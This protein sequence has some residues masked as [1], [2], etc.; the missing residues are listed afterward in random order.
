MTSIPLHSIFLSMAVK[1]R[2]DQEAM[3]KHYLELKNAA[4][5]AK[6]MKC[7]RQAV[8]DCLKNMRRRG[9]QVPRFGWESRGKERLKKLNGMI[10]KAGLKA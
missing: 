6:K 4:A 7:S 5:V 10:K 2:Y 3:L 1:P 8:L 9:V